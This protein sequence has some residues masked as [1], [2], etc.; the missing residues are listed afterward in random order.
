MLAYI[1][2]RTLYAVPILIGVNILTFWLFFVVNSPEEMARM[3]LGM[4]RVTPEAIE[5]WKEARGYDKPLLINS[6]ADGINVLT[7]TIFFE[8]S[9]RLFVFDFGSADDGRN[10]AHDIQQRMMPS[11]ALAIPI[12]I[13]CQEMEEIP[14]SPPR[15]VIGIVID[16]MRYDLLERFDTIFGEGG[17]KRLKKEGMV[18]KNC[19]STAS[20]GSGKNTYRNIN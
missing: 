19:F 2:R 14:E 9:V 16:Q 4:K 20:L 17:F 11:L 8:K 7:D 13:S 18:Y 12:F 3:Q 5:K 1:V 6:K 10:I 15:M